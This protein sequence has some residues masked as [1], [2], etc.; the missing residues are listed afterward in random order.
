[1]QH[2]L[3]GDPQLKGQIDNLGRFAAEGRLASPATENVAGLFG[4]A[5]LT[6]RSETAQSKEHYSEMIRLTLA[7]GAG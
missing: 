6:G 1:M 4:A 5:R 3:T 7:L 2:N